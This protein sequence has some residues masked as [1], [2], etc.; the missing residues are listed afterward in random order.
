M[1]NQSKVQS[2]KPKVVSE[3]DRLEMTRFATLWTATCPYRWT[4]R[5]TIELIEPLQTSAPADAHP[6]CSSW[7]ITFWDA[8]GSQKLDHINMHRMGE[9]SAPCLWLVNGE[10]FEVN[11]GQVVC[12]DGQ[13]MIVRL[14]W[15]NTRAAVMAN[16]GWHYYR[17]G[18]RPGRWPW[19]LW[20]RLCCFVHRA[21]RSL[22][23]LR[24]RNP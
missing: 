24:F 2:P 11:G 18:T 9:G 16:A 22:R 7:D 21:L 3:P 13:W 12:R 1:S 4:G 17:S 10:W 8:T 20:D 14:G 15:R 23:S 5:N 19:L 6:S